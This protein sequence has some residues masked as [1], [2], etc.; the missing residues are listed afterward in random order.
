M[1]HIDITIG[2]GRT[3]AQLRDLM[4]EVHTAVERTVGA[5]PE[6]IRV[7]VH[8]VPRTHWSTGGVTLAEMNEAR[9]AAQAQDVKEP[10]P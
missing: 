2:Q 6:H 1:P 5:R 8:E 9:Q 10:Q 3:P 4:T 7:A